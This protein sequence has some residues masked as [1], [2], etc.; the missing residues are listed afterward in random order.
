MG[1]IRGAQPPTESV[2]HFLVKLVL[3]AP[4]SFLSV[5]AASQA[6]VASVSHFFMKLVFAAPASFLSVASL[7]QLGLRG[8]V[9]ALCAYAELAIAQN[10]MAMHRR[11]ICFPPYG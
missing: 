2:T 5:A 7:V 9:G 3:G 8:E 4:L 6:A 10:S 1:R 11:V